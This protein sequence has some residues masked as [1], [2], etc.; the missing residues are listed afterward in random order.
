MQETQSLQFLFRQVVI[1]F[2]KVEVG[3]VNENSQRNITESRLST[4][5]HSQ[6]P[7][8]SLK[9]MGVWKIQENAILSQVKYSQQ[10]YPDDPDGCSSSRW[11]RCTCTHLL[12]QERQNH[13]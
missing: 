3:G 10:R 1:A 8:H 9:Q 11:S 7:G 4:I 2:K 13:N 5:C 6:C 12:Q